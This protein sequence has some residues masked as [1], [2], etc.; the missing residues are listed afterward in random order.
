MKCF[1]TVSWQCVSDHCLIAWG[2]SFDS[3]H[4]SVNWQLIECFCR[5]HRGLRNFTAD[6]SFAAYSIMSINLLSATIVEVDDDSFHCFFF[7]SFFLKKLSQCFY[8]KI[9]SELSDVWL[10]VHQCFIS[11]S[12]QILVLSLTGA[13]AIDCIL[14]IYLFFLMSFSP[15]K[16]WNHIKH[17]TF[18]FFLVSIDYFEDNN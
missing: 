10:F 3:I 7:L 15:Q 9:F 13:C 18:F 5:L 11:L 6:D 12:F 4:S 14:F 17:I 1:V 2:S 8:H 16:Y